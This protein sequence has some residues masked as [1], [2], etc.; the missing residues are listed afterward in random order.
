MLP[1]THSK[2]APAD[3]EQLAEQARLASELLKALSHETR[4]LIL[5]M[6][7]EGEMSVSEIENIMQLPQAKVSQQLARL[8]SD[9]LVTTRRE[10]RQ[11]YY[12]LA[13]TQVSSIVDSL[14][15]I[16]CTNETEREN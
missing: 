16:F 2:G 7:C 15:S 5:S 10:G 3:F 13:D 12:Q 8:R 11:I 9:N 6:L 14:Y 4:L 1:L